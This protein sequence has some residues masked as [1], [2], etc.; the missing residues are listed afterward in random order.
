MATQRTRYGFGV[1]VPL[2]Y[3]QAVERAKAALKEQGFGVLTEIDIK[4]T[5]KEKR[6]V[7]FRRYVI[8]GACNPPLAE[9]ALNAELDLG[10]LLPCNVVV[11]EEGEGSVVAAMDPEPVLGLV[12]NPALE[13]IARE[14]R[15]RLEQAI[16]QAGVVAVRPALDAR[17]PDQERGRAG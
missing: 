5:M 9:R 8:L 16:D 15:T 2:P 3:E 7:D 4:Q 14:V 6:G 12:Q 10:L 17:G 11:Y 1:Q 13:E